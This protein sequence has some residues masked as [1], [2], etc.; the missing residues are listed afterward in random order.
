MSRFAPGCQGLGS[1]NAYHPRPH[2]QRPSQRTGSQKTKRMLFVR[3]P[4]HPNREQMEGIDVWGSPG[5]RTLTGAMP[6][7]QQA[8]W[9]DMGPERPWDS[10]SRSPPPRS[11]HTTKERIAPRGM[12]RRSWM[13]ALGIG[14]GTQGLVGP[15]RR[16]NYPLHQPADRAAVGSAWW[17]VDLS[18]LSQHG[19]GLT[20]GAAGGHRAPPARKNMCHSVSSGGGRVRREALGR[21]RHAINPVQQ[22]SIRFR[23]GILPTYGNRVRRSPGGASMSTICAQYLLGRHD[24][25]CPA[26]DRSCQIGGGNRECSTCARYWIASRRAV[27]DILESGAFWLLRSQPQPRLKNASPLRVFEAGRALRAALAVLHLARSAVRPCNRARRLHGSRQWRP[28]QSVAQ[29]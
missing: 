7:D 25:W 18:T 5:A 28:R 22:I 11:R 19:K 12:R 1:A 6:P 10:N 8:L 9:C 27:A 4:E 21:A 14:N 23:H 26:P 24:A 3:A 13:K 20:F 15:R 17:S 29:G 16:S 2:C